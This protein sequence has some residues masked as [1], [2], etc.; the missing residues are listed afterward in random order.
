VLTVLLPL[1]VIL[2]SGAL[3]NWTTNSRLP[4]HSLA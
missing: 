1:V 4:F 3:A 2:A